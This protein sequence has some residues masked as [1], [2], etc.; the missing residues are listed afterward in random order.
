MNILATLMQED[1]LPKPDK[2]DD[3]DWQKKFEARFNE[4]LPCL[5]EFT[6]EGLKKWDINRH[7]GS[8]LGKKFSKNFTGNEKNLLVVYPATW[9]FL[10]RVKHIGQALKGILKKV[11][12]F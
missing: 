11:V 10:T 12:L 1:Y 8:E 3:K 7:F 6:S 4:Y 9:L 2:F 5:E